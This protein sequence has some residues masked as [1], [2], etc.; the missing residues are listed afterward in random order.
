MPTRNLSFVLKEGESQPIAI[1]D[2]DVEYYTYSYFTRNGTATSPEDY[3]AQNES[4]SSDDDFYR[5]IVTVDDDIYED[6]HGIS[7][8]FYIDYNADITTLEGSGQNVHPVVNHWSGVLTFT[9]DDSADL[10]LLTLEAKDVKEGKD[11]EAKIVI[12]A[13]HAA[14]F[15]YPVTVT[16]AGSSSD[17]QTRE[18]TVVMKAYEKSVTATIGLVDDYI[19]EGDNKNIV[20]TSENFGVFAKSEYSNASGTLA[21]INDDGP[22]VQGTSPSGKAYLELSE[23]YAPGEIVVKLSEAV[24]YDI[25]LTFNVE[26]GEAAGNVS[27]RQMTVAAGETSVT[28]APLEGLADGRTLLTQELKVKVSGRA[29]SGDEKIYFDSNGATTAQYTLLVRDQLF[30]LLENQGQWGEAASWITK[31]QDGKKDFADALKTFMTAEDDIALLTKFGKAAQAIGLGV[32]ALAIAGD[33]ASTLQ[34]VK[35]KPNEDQLKKLA[36]IKAVA[37]AVDIAASLAVSAGDGLL[38]AALLIVFAPGVVPGT[39]TALA[40]VAVSAGTAFLYSTISNRVKGA[41]IDFFLDEDHSI[42]VPAASEDGGSMNGTDGDDLF[43][44]PLAKTTIHEG[45]NGGHDTVIAETDFVLPD[46]VET[47]L[48]VASAK[49]GI[50]NSMDNL[51]VGNLEDNTLSGEAGNDTLLGGAGFDTLIGGDGDDVLDGGTNPSDQGD[52]M[53]GGAGDDTYYVDSTWDLVDEGS[54]FPDAGWGGTD[55][56]ISTANWFWDVYSVGEIDRIAENAADPTHAGVT[57]VGGIFDNVLYGHSGTDI[58]F[59]RG[60]NDT[61]IPGDGIDWISLSTLGLTDQ[62]AY[63]GVDGHNT[64][65]ATPRTSGPNSYDI[66]FEFDPSRDKVDVSAY[67]DQYSSG[68]D[69]LSHAVNDGAGN[70]FIALGDGLDYV[71]FVGLSKD[72][73]LASDFVV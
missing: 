36:Y 55:T 47:L 2:P 48:L 3:I 69:V 56:I 29:V 11:S 14:S 71:Y 40:S 1:A 12:T 51:L 53:L 30:W 9:I 25:V 31:V 64:I 61:Y 27:A 22:V 39:V 5:S 65:V 45:P 52:I 38:A 28:F 66:I 7:E 68:A 58:L 50:G 59:G 10:P 26:G 49:T 41:V 15:D 23:K 19:R 63:A 37:E 35:G 54:V 42:N 32:T 70:S 6:E 67:G 43:L 33:L 60:G 17:F 62:N 44:P 13:N 34:A 21:V 72:Q 57:F 8:Q 4:G 73:L 20:P 18:V 46:N 16:V 24:P